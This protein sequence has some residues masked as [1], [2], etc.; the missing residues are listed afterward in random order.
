MLN[1]HGSSS[2]K[3]NK[4]TL[5]EAVRKNRDAHKAA[6][7]EAFADY[8]ADLHVLLEKALPQ[9]R[10]RIDPRPD[11]V[12]LKAPPLHVKT[13][14][15]VISMLEHSVG[16]EVELTEGIYREI[17]LDEWDWKDEFE[18]ISSSYSNKSRR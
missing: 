11:I 1:Q 9:I 4:N 5:L 18:A 14:D 13:Y 16:T 8:L 17:V 10:D 15:R 3:M 12:K 2:I 6:Y 7:E